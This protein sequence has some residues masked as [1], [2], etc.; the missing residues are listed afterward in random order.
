MSLPRSIRIIMGTVLLTCA[1]AQAQSGANVDMKRLLGADSETGQWM[2]HSR[3]FDEQYFSPLKQIND[4]NIGKLGLAWFA[5]LP[6]NQNVESSPLM[7]DGVLYLTLPW[8]KVV[9]FDARTGKQLWLYDP[10]VAGAWNI[11]LCCGVDN[12]GAAAW[13]GK[14]I[15]GTLDGRLIA[16]SAKTGKP[17]WSVKS[18]PDERRY[19]ITG[20][21]RIANGTVFIGSAGGEFDARGYI[22]AY[23]A[24]NG[25]LLWRFW[26][27]PGDPAKGFENKA[28]EMA[29]AT[30][31]TPGWWQ[32]GGGG[33]VWDAITYD[34]VTDLVIF[35]TGNGTPGDAVKRDA[36]GGD[37][38]FMTSIVAVHAKDGSY[39][40]HYQTTPWETWDYDT[41]QQLMLLDIEIDGKKH[42]VVS[43]ASKNGFFY[44]LDA[45]T[46]KLL[47]AKPYTD[48]NWADGVDMQTGRPNVVAAART[49]LTNQVFNL[50]PGPAGGHAWQSMSYSPITK[51]VY[52]PATTHWQLMGPFDARQKFLAEHPDTKTGFTGRLAAWDPVAQREVWRTEEFINPTGGVQVTAGALAT[53][54]NV[55]FHGNLPKR[56]FVAYRATDGKRLWSFD[57]KTAV[58]AGAISYAVGREQYVA[59]AVGGP[60]PG[61]YYAP[62]GARL[63]VFKLGSKTML[64]DLPPFTE[65][66]ISAAAQFADADTIRHGAQLFEAQCQTCH[67]RNGAARSTFP[68]LRRSPSLQSQELLDAIVLQGALSQRGMASFRDYLKEGDTVALRGYLISLAETARK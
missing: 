32:G 62:N 10:Q 67:G 5:D 63:L 3:T 47:S 42:H 64:P 6:T 20:A 65:R 35:G 56:E 31:K 46:G 37:N 17:V 45:A 50:A 7:I 24:E 57:T 2:S 51:L 38:L 68:D 1:Q 58:L 61:G 36:A 54:G 16:L 4:Q 44:N 59:L 8:S 39:A 55:V 26:T 53:A 14:I 18:T 34:P 43:Q 11:N 41:G 52:I 9:A 30:W 15:Y 13:K 25:K 19:S 60:V 23:D 49:N 29:A 21:P 40:W 12:R 66:P 28:M 33:T 27:V 22:D 48:V